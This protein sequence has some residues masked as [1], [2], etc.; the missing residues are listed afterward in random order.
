MYIY[1]FIVQGHLT[2]FFGCWC[3][4]KPLRSTSQFDKASE[5][6]RV[7]VNASVLEKACVRGEM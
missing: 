2:V 5:Q 3:L 1:L 6:V 7:C 4:C